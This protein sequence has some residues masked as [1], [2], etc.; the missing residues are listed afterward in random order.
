M[1]A[2]QNELD[3]R[4]DRGSPERS[5]PPSPLS[6]YSARSDSPLTTLH[7]SLPGAISS[8]ST[9]SKSFLIGGSQLYTL[10]LTASP[11]PLV[12]RILLT[13]I[14]SPAFDDCDAFLHEFRSEHSGWVRASHK[15]LEQ[16]VGFEVAEGER[17]ERGVRYAFEMW[18]WDGK[19][20]GKEEK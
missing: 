11:T 18:V 17:E 10:A 9:T 12:D 5:S 14:A 19:K 1:S 15:D 8:L 6:P 2:R 3:K 20:E 4:R 7:S 16:F 13:R